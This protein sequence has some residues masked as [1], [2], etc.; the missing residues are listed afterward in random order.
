ML[1]V[2]YQK[3]KIMSTELKLLISKLARDTQIPYRSLSLAVKKAILSGRI[4]QQDLIHV[5]RKVAD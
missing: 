2:S 4:T 5:L 3:E 1:D